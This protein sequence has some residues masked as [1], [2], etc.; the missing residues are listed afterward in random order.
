MGDKLVINRLNQAQL[1]Y[2]LTIRGLPTGT[3]DQMRKYL[4]RARKLER[5]G[6][7]LSYPT[8]P[9]IFEEDK[10]AIDEVISTVEAGISDFQSLTLKSRRYRNSETRLRYALIRLEHLKP[11]KP[12]E[13]AYKR[14]SFAKILSLLDSLEDKTGNAASAGPH[15]SSDGGCSG[16]GEDDDS[17]LV[18]TRG[19][20]V[21][22]STPRPA[23]STVAGASPSHL[24][25]VPVYRWGL[26]FSGD[27]HGMSV[28]AFLQ[29]VEEMC[30]ARGVSKCEVL[31]SAID[32][33]EGGALIWYRAVRNSIMDWN[34]FVERLRIEFEPFNYDEKLCEEIR[35]RT[36][37]KDEQIGIYLATMRSLFSRLGSPPS[38]DQQVKILMR[39]ILPF[40][41]TQLALLNISSYAELKNYCRQLEERRES[42]ESFA[43]PPRKSQFCLEPDLAYAGVEENLAEVRI[44]EHTESAREDMKG[45]S[46]NTRPLESVI[47]YNC[48]MPGHKAIGC[49]SPRK[50][51]CYKCQKLGYTT[52]TCPD[53]SQ[54]G[55]G[56]SR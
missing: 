37:G 33:F 56:S 50:L 23:I 27:K 41:Q 29:R 54:S 26:K 9:Y 6:A 21:L 39:N 19:R 47:C 25:P 10:I 20:N 13:E 28:H 1:A 31:H 55:N 12:E 24:K 49:A 4:S 17:S 3:V 52:K 7:S 45:I 18:D 48:N 8:Y 15:H 5:E 14:E 36:Q 34:S 46:G 22:A 11:T 35:R 40:F 16:T 53:C 38:E 42:V 30:Q 43:P 44:E 2:L 51:R 32:L